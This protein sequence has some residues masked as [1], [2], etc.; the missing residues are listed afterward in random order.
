MP[1]LNVNLN[2]L[3]YLDG[4]KTANPRMKLHDTTLSIMGLPTEAMNNTPIDLAPGESVTLA[5][6]LR[7]ILVSPVT[8]FS[9]SKNQATARL[10]GS[11]GQRTGRLDGDATTQWTIS[12]SQELVTLTHTGTGTAPT[13]SS[14]QA[15]DGVTIDAPF[16]SLNRGD[17]TVVKVGA[18]YIQFVN[19]IAAGE[20][21]TGQVDVYSSGPV[22]KGDV[23]DLTSSA[24]AFPNRG[25]F[26]ITRVTD[27][28]VEFSNPNAVPESSISGVLPG[29]LNIYRDAFQWMLVA[30]EHRAVVRLNGSTNDSVEVTPPVDGDL[31][32]NP[33]IM[34]KRG[35]VYQ[36]QIS[37]PTNFQ[38][39]GFL[40]LAE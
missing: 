22:Q 17:F 23:L 29:E 35:R 21:V 27:S 25:Q 14:M 12:V 31:T 6:T 1:L 2:V 9:V 20:T 13:F 32:N 40:F 15:G 4:P 5:S 26:A 10:T 28:F 38:L 3:G 18:S 34:L 7:S 30:V 37:N 24:F 39:K 8:V 19:P 11:F 36:V 16:S 33:G